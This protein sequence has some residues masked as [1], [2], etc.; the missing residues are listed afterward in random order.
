MNADCG[1]CHFQ[2]DDES[3]CN[4]YDDAHYAMQALL[5]EAEEMLREKP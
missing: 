1:E 5:M 3:G 2:K 4:R